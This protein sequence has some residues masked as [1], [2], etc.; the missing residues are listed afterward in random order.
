MVSPVCMHIDISLTMN[1]LSLSLPTP[2]PPDTRVMD[3][4]PRLFE[5]S[6]PLESLWPVKLSIQPET[7]TSRPRPSSRV[8]FTPPLNLVSN[9]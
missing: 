3:F 8:T 7:L 6:V 9:S 1:S 2:P 5:L 4:T